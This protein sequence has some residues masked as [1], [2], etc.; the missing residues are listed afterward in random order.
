V[1]LQDLAPTLARMLGV[2]LP[3]ATGR[4]LD[5]ALVAGTRPPRAMLLL[6]LDGMRADY[7]DRFSAELPTLARLRREGAAFDHA[8]VTYAPSITSAGHATIATGT[9]PRLHGIVT[10]T[11]F[12]RTSGKDADIFPALPGPRAQDQG[13]AGQLARRNRLPG[14]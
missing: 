11:I 8:R 12:D 4:P 7:L 13:Q 2:V 3:G 10:N 14:P 5:E 1:A 9:D 6:V